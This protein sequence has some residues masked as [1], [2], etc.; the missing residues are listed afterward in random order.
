MI[1]A[2]AVEGWADLLGIAA[3][4]FDAL[5]DEAAPGS[6][7]YLEF[8]A[9]AYR[10]ENAA[11]YAGDAADDLRDAEAEAEERDTKMSRAARPAGADGARAAT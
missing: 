5:A 3:R 4:H 1:P 8:L 2:R 9:L 6:P 11:D 7:E 10:C